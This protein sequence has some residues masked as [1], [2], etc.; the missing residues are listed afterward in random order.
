MVV[1]VY[2]DDIG[3]VLEQFPDKAR[4]KNCFIVYLHSQSLSTRVVL[5]PLLL[6]R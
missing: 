6:N 2:D 5:M 3:D 1:K 4:L